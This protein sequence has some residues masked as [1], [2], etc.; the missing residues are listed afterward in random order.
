[1]AR[2]VASTA[3]LISGA[4]L[5]MVVVFGGFAFA[6][7]LPM[8]QLGFGMAVAIAIDATL[9]RLVIVP[10]SM[11]LLGRW[12]WWMPGR[13]IPGP[14]AEE[15]AAAVVPVGPVVPVVPIAPVAP[16]APEPVAE[17]FGVALE[18]PEP[19]RALTEEDL[20]A[21]W[22]MEVSELRNVQSRR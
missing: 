16:V 1:V 21:E 10:A 14:Q 8:K 2:G 20:S 22:V 7:I 3:P 6:G 19:V 4:A 9:V 12:N 11:R 17:A 13:G 15:P 5:L 18:S